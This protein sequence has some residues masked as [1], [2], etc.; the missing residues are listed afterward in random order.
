MRRCD[1]CV[2]ARAVPGPMPC[3]PDVWECSARGGMVVIHPVERALA[4]RAWASRHRLH[5]ED[6]SEC[7]SGINSQS[8]YQA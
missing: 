4:C 6:G 1:S 3:L 2:H 5:V 7:Q 8:A